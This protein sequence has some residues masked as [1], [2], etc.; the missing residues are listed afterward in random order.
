[1]AFIPDY[2]NIALPL[3]ELT[4]GNKLF[5]LAPQ[6]KAFQAFVK[7]KE[8]LSSSQVSIAPDFQQPFF[9]QTDASD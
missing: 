7:L 8:V 4:K 5:R 6:G 9:I 3:T 1:M 2:T